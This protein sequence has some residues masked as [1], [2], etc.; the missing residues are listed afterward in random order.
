MGKIALITGASKGVGRS[1]SL[2]FAKKKIRLFL[3]SRN[4]NNLKKLKKEISK[5]FNFNNVEII[6]GDV[7]SE[8]NVKKIEKI[9]KKSFG[10]PDI[11]IN[12]TGGPPSGNFTKFNNKVWEKNIKNNLMS[13]INFTNMFHKKMIKNKWG[14]IITISSTVAKEPSS[15]MVISS[16]LRSGVSGFN[17][18]ISFELAKNNITVNTILL[19]GVK[20]D[21]L[22]ELIKKNSKSRKIK[23]ETYLNQVQKS[24]P[25]GRFAEP[26]EIS[27]LVN[28]LI[29]E[30]G[31]YITG[32][33]IVIDGGLS[34]SL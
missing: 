30:H 14:R 15:N 6:Q 16:T 22:K 4:L 28:F 18:S 25:A 31:S 9:C 3:V 29:S 5:K 7:S 1:I 19:G 24:I 2:E 27:N 26:E 10:L 11:L 8:S 12:N 23:Y 21:R 33:N 34:K 20:T 17:K 32:Q 13:V